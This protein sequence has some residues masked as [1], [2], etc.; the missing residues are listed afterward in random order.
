[1]TFTRAC[2]FHS[3]PAIAG[4]GSDGECAALAS[5]PPAPLSAAPTLSQLRLLGFSFLNSGLGNTGMAL[6]CFFLEVWQR[7]EHPWL[8]WKSVEY[9]APLLVLHASVTS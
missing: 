3:L 6:L 2:T 8:H 5:R 7:V 4:S 9:K 1:M